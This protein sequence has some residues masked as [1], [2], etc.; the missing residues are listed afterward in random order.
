MLPGEELNVKQLLDRLNVAR[1][2]ELADPARAAEVVDDISRLLAQLSSKTKSISVEKLAHVVAAPNVHVY[3]L[4]DELGKV[5]GMTTLAVDTLL[6][7]TKAW[8]E[9]VVVDTRCRCRGYARQLLAFMEEEGRRLGAASLNLTSRPAREAA[10]RLYR[11][12]GYVQRETNV[13]KLPL[14]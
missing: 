4:Y 9:D 13:Y 11:R 10:N 1:I 6:T 2:E 8:V 14:A 12:A 7:G 5:S 3:L